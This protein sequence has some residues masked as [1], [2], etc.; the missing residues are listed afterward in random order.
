MPSPFGMV[1]FYNSISG[2]VIE[3][4]RFGDTIQAHIPGWHGPFGTK[5]EALDF[6]ARNKARNPGWAQPSGFFGTVGNTVKHGATSAAGAAL[7]SV[8][9]HGD[10]RQLALR[11]VEVILGAL[12]I[13]VA[14]ENVM[15]ET[16]ATNIVQGVKR[17]G[18]TAG[19]VA[20]L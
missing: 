17:Y 5:Q 14:L 4:T 8:G 16:G 18:K 3:T 20:A 11:T 6:Y 9:I 15:K 13:I 10:L 1:W 7:G 19:K 12:L 2:S